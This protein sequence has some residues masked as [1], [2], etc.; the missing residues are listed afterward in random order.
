MTT[1]KDAWN[2]FGT[3]LSDLGHKLKDH[4]EHENEDKNA[5]K[6]VASEEDAPAAEIGERLESLGETIKDAFEALGNAIDDDAVRRDAKDA[7]RLL[8]DAMD[9]T[10]TEVGDELRDRFGRS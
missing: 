6:E 10:F 2:E 3:K 8:V 4:Y 5:D 7:G 1:S 9:A